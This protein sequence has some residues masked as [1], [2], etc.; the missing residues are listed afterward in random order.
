MRFRIPVVILVVAMVAVAVSVMSAPPITAVKVTDQSVSEKLTS[1]QAEI[2][3]LHTQVA[4]DEKKLA[5]TEDTANKARTVA[6][7][8]QIAYDHDMPALKPL[9]AKVAAFDT[10]ISTLETLPGKLQ[11]LDQE[12]RTHRHQLNNDFGFHQVDQFKDVITS[13]VEA[14]KRPT[15]PPVH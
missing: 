5:A 12:Y 11:S 15:S 8:V 3:A 1:M 6:G 9:P 10:R 7:L 2:A 13:G 4:A 14:L